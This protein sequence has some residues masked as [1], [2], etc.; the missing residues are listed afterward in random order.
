MFNNQHIEP[1]DQELQKLINDQTSIPDQID[2]IKKNQIFKRTDLLHANNS[3]TFQDFIEMI[4][5]IIDKV[6]RKYKITFSPDEGSKVKIP[7][8]ESL[9]NPWIQYSLKSRVPRD[10]Y[11]KPRPRE[12]FVEKNS[13]GD[14]E[15]KGVVYSQIFDYTVQFD[16]LASGYKEA[17]L[18]MNAFE[19]AIFNYTA[20]FKQNGVSELLFLKQFTDTDLDVYRNNVSVRSLQ[21]KVTIERNRIQYDALFGENIEIV[22]DMH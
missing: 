16:I 20:Y 4:N 11:L 17:N 3:A 21:Y 12:E 2:A 7:A 19:D 13:N 1:Y 6:L 8:T 9:D 15:R 22:E 5:R 14:V 18:V 10:I